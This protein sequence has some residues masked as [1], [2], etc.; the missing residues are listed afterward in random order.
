MLVGI[1][2]SRLM[3]NTA[4]LVI[5]FILWSPLSSFSTLLD[6]VNTVWKKRHIF[7][8]LFSNPVFLLLW[9]M[10]H[11]SK[12]DSHTARRHKL[13]E[14]LLLFCMLALFL[15]DWQFHILALCLDGCI[16]SKGYAQMRDNYEDK[17]RHLSPTWEVC[18]QV[19][20]DPAAWYCAELM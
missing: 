4:Q 11:Q 16:G 10:A 9:Q 18:F 1:N 12:R 20:A 15:F 5:F 6:A 13:N 2:T 19:S 7:C 3:H 14:F 8:V 17:C